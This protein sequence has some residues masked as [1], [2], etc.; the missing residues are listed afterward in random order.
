MSVKPVDLQATVPKSAEV[1]KIAK[2][3]QDEGQSRLA[4]IATAFR[5]EIEKSQRQ[6]RTPAKAAGGRIERDRR[7]AR[8]ER[9]EENQDEGDGSGEKE[10]G[11]HGSTTAVDPRKG[12]MLDVLL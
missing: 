8:R 6:V 2:M 10:D 1:G 4:E 7:N 5:G 12:G 11:G 3:K 9:G